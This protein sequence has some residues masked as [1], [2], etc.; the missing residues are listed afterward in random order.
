MGG[1]YRERWGAGTGRGGQSWHS[2]EDELC[3]M[4][5]LRQGQASL[6]SPHHISQ[7]N[8]YARSGSLTFDAVFSSTI[9]SVMSST[10]FFAS[11]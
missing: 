4:K 2:C 5:D 9:L 6:G 7:L 11:K 3:R 8:C 1:E 10:V